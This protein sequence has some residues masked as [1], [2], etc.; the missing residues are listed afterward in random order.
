MK[1]PKIKPLSYRHRTLNE[2]VDIILMERRVIPTVFVRL[3]IYGGA[4]SD[5]TGK[6]GLYRFTAKLLKQGT[7][8]KSANDLTYIIESKGAVV[9]VH[10][11]FHTVVINGQFL[12]RDI[13][14][15]LNLIKDILREPRFSRV[16]I[17][18][19]K[20]LTIGNI[21]AI[22]DEPGQLCGF[23]HNKNVFQDHPYGRRIIGTKNAINSITKDD[24]INL[25]QEKL[26]K[27]KILLSV[28][29]DI[30][31]EKILSQVQRLFADFNEKAH[32]EKD[33]KTKNRLRS[34][35][36]YLVN[37]PDLTQ[38]HIRIG[39][40]GISRQDTDFFKLKVTNTLFGGSFTSRLNEIIRVKSG[41]T[42][43]IRSAFSPLK[44]PGSVQIATFTKTN[45]AAKT[46]EMIL[47]EMKK[48]GE[49]PVSR[50]ELHRTQ[51]YLT[52]LFPLSL[53]TNKTIAQQLSDMYFYDLPKTYIEDYCS[54]IT[55][56][57]ESDIQYSAKKYF[58]QDDS[59]VTVLGNMENIKTELETFGDAAVVNY[60][61]IL[62]T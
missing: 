35:K 11:T 46:I 38:A 50:R 45:S 7:K 13:E 15:G 32:P 25:H 8:T 41:L 51:Q 27:S 42:Y 5:P 60:Q 9:T 30:N 62:N 2:Q 20:K 39:N 22:V 12:S 56:V 49:S 58:S 28:I 26:L 6:E 55:D 53:E 54:N 4:V 40:V 24:I 18:R 17:N 59:V 47:S 36:I 10:S 37:K 48:I 19:L 29:G 1:I 33:G 31:S 14:W 16:E 23:I 3:I 57:S 43:S 52:G 61:E 34:R 44:L 21:E